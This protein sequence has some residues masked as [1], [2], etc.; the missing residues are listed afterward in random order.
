MSCR[1]EP[2][3][4][5]RSLL[6]V[7]HLWPSD[8]HAKPQLGDLTSSN[9]GKSEIGEQSARTFGADSSASHCA[10]DDDDALFIPRSAA[11]SDS[12][13]R[14]PVDTPHE[15][16]DGPRGKSDSN[17]PSTVDASSC[18]GLV[19]DSALVADD[20]DDASEVASAGM[21][22]RGRTDG[23][24]K[25]VPP[26]IC[27]TIL[28]ADENSCDRFLLPCGGEIGR[29]QMSVDREARNTLSRQM[30]RCE[31]KGETVA[32][33]R[34]PNS[35]S[36]WY[37]YDPRGERFQMK[38]EEEVYMERGRALYLFGAC[39]DTALAI[40]KWGSR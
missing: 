35:C 29:K 34:F 17:V 8:P 30:L 13:S 6:N 28:D 14:Q 37:A 4:L 39:R 25:Q 31:G 32:L 22:G 7:S 18:R 11:S 1:R 2:L 5:V 23:G 27:C 9:R 20:T 33:K 24:A 10:S 15:L 26:S 36:V 12:R 3:C 16:L 21:R 40:M 19:S 38:E